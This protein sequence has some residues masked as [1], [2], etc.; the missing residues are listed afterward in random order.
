MTLHLKAKVYV[1]TVAGPTSC[2]SGS[3]DTSARLD[4]QAAMTRN[5]TRPLPLAGRD[6]NINHAGSPDDRPQVGDRP[7]S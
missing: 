7:K 6:W 2:P 1:S 4:V 3:F 5:R